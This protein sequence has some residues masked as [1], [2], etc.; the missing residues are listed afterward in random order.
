MGLRF[1][2]LSYRILLPSVSISL[3][4]QKDLKL[5]TCLSG[6]VTEFKKYAVK[7]NIQIMFL[8][9]AECANYSVSMLGGVQLQAFM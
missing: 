8:N 6:G 2:N 3:R 9:S 7:M 1:V 4:R 5:I